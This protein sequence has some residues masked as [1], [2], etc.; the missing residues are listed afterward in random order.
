[1][2]LTAQYCLLV[3]GSIIS[4]SSL[5]AIDGNSAPPS[6]VCFSSSTKDWA[7]SSGHSF[8]CGSRVTSGRSTGRHWEIDMTRP[9]G[10]GEH[11]HS[12]MHAH[13]RCLTQ[14]RHAVPTCHCIQE[15]VN[16]MPNK[17][18]FCGCK[19]AAQCSAT[20]ILFD[21]YDVCHAFK[22]VNLLVI[23]CY[24]QIDRV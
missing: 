14:W 8:T 6:Q 3:A 5:D 12:I 4:G 13:N 1:M 23:R 10:P 21:F 16:S 22:V 20:Q 9:P 24:I 7:F 18:V 19:S 2:R 15:A 11:P 17:K